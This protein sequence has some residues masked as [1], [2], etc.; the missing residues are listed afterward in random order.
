M[1]DI[2]MLYFLLVYQVIMLSVALKRTKYNLGIP[3][4]IM[5]IFLLFGYI[6]YVIGYE[7][8]ANPL[9]LKTFL[10]I[11]IGYS[12]AFVCSFFCKRITIPNKKSLASYYSRK[13]NNKINI[14]YLYYVSL[15][16][17]TLYA[18]GIYMEG[19]HQGLPFFSAISYVKDTG[20]EGICILSRQ[21]FKVVTMSS[22]IAIFLFVYN[23]KNRIYKKRIKRKL[24]I[25]ILLGMIITILSGSRGDILKVASAFVCVYFL[26]FT[27]KEKNTKKFI[28]IGLI[29]IIAIFAVFY[30]SRSLVKS[31]GNSYSGSLIFSDYICYYFGSPYE[32]M[33]QKLQ[34]L[35]AYH[36]NYFGSNT[37]FAGVIDVLQRFGFDFS[38]SGVSGP[39]FVY[40]GD[41]DFGGNVATQYFPMLADFGYIGFPIVMLVKCFAGNYIY[42]RLMKKKNIFVI[43]LCSQVYSMYTFSFYSGMTYY[44]TCFSFAMSLIVL[45]FLYY[46]TFMVRFR[47]D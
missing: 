11:I 15:L 24:L 23:L 26:F 10:V 6:F 29:A 43:I 47:K 44:Y 36:S 42:G 35:S 20:G 4:N 28:K 3:T 1:S 33:N 39:E 46:L 16:F 17:F 12:I 25:M 37:L 45:Y 27:F 34:N 31:F 38:N 8:W 5:M 40:L 21:G 14:N 19:R 41:W 32:V 30:G 13:L 9:K 18:L 7:L 22:Y 2:F